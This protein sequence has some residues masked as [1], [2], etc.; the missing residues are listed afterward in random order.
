[1]FNRVKNKLVDLSVPKRNSPNR[2]LRFARHTL[3]HVNQRFLELGMNS[4]NLNAPS[5]EVSFR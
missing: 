3:V 4:L 1:M 5:R 2:N